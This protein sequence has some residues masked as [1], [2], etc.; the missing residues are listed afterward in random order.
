MTR[1]KRFVRQLH[2]ILC[3]LLDFCLCYVV[4]CKIQQFSF[5]NAL[6]YNRLSQT[7]LNINCIML[8]WSKVDCRRR[9]VCALQTAIFDTL[10]WSA[11]YYCNCN[12]LH[13]TAQH[14][15]KLQKYCITQHCKSLHYTTLHCTA[16]HH[17]ALHHTALHSNTR[18]HTTQHCTTSHFNTLH[19]TTHYYT[20]K[21][22]IA[23]N[24]PCRVAR[25]RDVEDRRSQTFITGFLSSPLDVT[26]CS[27]IGIEVLHFSDIP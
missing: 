18:H 11:S 9:S 6:F 3:R 15:A 4:R 14:D 1:K 13:C 20:A 26:K 22:Y 10:Q 19:Y 24:S 5:S 17:T 23:L 12:T 2:S 16:L 8:Q 27:P 21:K 25:G 7:K